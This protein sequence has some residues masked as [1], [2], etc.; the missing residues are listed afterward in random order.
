METNKSGKI[1]IFIWRCIKLFQGI[2]PSI[3]SSITGKTAMPFRRRPPGGQR[4]GRPAGRGNI[5]VKVPELS[6]LQS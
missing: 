4:G 1:R 6:I 2:D 5:P 3:L